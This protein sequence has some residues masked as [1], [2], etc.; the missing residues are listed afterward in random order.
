MATV[1]ATGPGSEAAAVAMPIA[2]EGVARWDASVEA[3]QS[4]LPSLSF[5]EPQLREQELT[6]GGAH[7]EAARTEDPR[8]K[9][10]AH[11]IGVKF[12]TLASAQ[13]QKQQ[14]QQPQQRPQ[15]SIL[16]QVHG[17]EPEAGRSKVAPP[18]G[19][20]QI[21][22]MDSPLLR[23]FSPTHAGERGACVLVHLIVFAA[24]LSPLLPILAAKCPL[25]R[26]HAD[27]TWN[28]VLRNGG[29]GRGAG[30]VAQASVRLEHRLVGL[31]SWHALAVPIAPLGVGRPARRLCGGLSGRH[32]AQV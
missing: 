22:S 15:Q 11:G 30:A 6:D 20:K 7:G 31:R 12:S 9:L 25:L 29:S 28:L 32:L 27:A 26:R 4:A 19:V 1:E 16:V 18:R 17:I 2:G 8:A 14:L 24:L 10:A 5:S 13:Q 23:A 3:R 21:P